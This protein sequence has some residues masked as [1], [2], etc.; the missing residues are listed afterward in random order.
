MHC[1]LLESRRLLS[2]VYVD[3]NS[4]GMVHD[5]ASWATAYKHLQSALSAA[6]SGDTIE[7]AQG[8]YK[9]T[10]GTDRTASF[11]LKDGV[12][13]EGGYAG[14]L[15]ASP[16]A[17]NVKGNPTILS[18]D[19]GV[20]GDSSDNSYHVVFGQDVDAT[21]SLDGF[22]ITGGAGTDTFDTNGDGGGMLLLTASPTLSRCVFSDNSGKMGGAIYA[23]ASSPEFTDCDFMKN[24]AA[25]GGAILDYS[26]SPM[27][28]NCS[29]V[30]NFGTNLGGGGMLNESGSAPVLANCTFSGN[31][32]GGMDNFSST[33]VVT[34][35]IFSG[36][37][38]D[39]GGGI[40]NSSSSPLVSD[41]IFVAN[42]GGGVFNGSSSPV[43]TNCIFLQNRNDAL[44]DDG[45]SPSVLN[46]TF[47]GNTG[48][49]AVDG[50][51]ASSATL[52]NCIL[53]DNTSAENSGLFDESPSVT[54][55]SYSDVQG[56]FTGTGNINSDPL[57]VDA[58]GGNLQLKAGSPTIDLGN[59]EALPTGDITDLAGSP[60]VFNGVV[61]MGAYEYEGTAA[62]QF[63]TAASAEVAAGTADSESI[64]TVNASFGALSEVGAIPAGVVFRDNGNGTAT[65]YGTPVNGSRGVYNLTF[66]ADAGASGTTTQD[67][68]LT[69]GKAPAIT[70][71]NHTT[72]MNGTSNTFTVAGS[73]YP[74][75]AFT[76][77]GALPTGVTLVDNHNGTATIS[78][79]AA[80]ASG[81]VY[82][83]TIKA[84]DGLKPN[85]KQVFVLTVS[86]PPSISS[87]S[88]A[89]F[90]A[91]GNASFAIDSTGFP[92]A[93]ITESGALPAG[94]TLQDNNDGTA[95]LTG[96]PAPGSE[97]VYDLTLKAKN[98][99]KPNA[100][101]VFTLTIVG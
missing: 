79:T 71:A 17:R 69:V 68:L 36:N 22:T 28:T 39:I 16:G 86:N 63:T 75:P 93:S 72:F 23:M 27:L 54:T 32:G 18:G 4:P 41:C 84:K 26:S 42:T 52:T 53:W 56:G 5:G 1:E 100:S 70:S 47:E 98:G 49:L 101:Q 87:A 90:H 66:S 94:I 2:V 14:D 77:A 58:A 3:A 91:G 51:G 74:A 73:G 24:T 21:A 29:F 46:C 80:T 85:A 31:G 83:V 20:A 60:R 10:T 92:E 6:V 25:S 19:I 48:G 99:V 8:T 38:S 59:T 45:S 35:C 12:A 7:V 65:L 95:I 11:G 62:P 88:S 82:S 40:Y 34:N 13:I 64:S 61:D 9:P 55:V 97:G 67:F 96:V 89:T 78:G 33:P 50:F 76:E 43:L 30:G 57:F 81:G 15:T 44:T 37:S